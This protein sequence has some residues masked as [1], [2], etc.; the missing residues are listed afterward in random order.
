MAEAPNV[1]SPPVAGRDGIDPQPN[2]PPQGGSSAPASNNKPAVLT[3]D[4]LVAAIKAKMGTPDAT[5]AAPIAVAGASL[6]SDNEPPPL[7]GD[8]SPIQNQFP[9]TLR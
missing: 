3:G 5:A 9:P 2:T 1:I 6:V 7:R 8:N 4:A